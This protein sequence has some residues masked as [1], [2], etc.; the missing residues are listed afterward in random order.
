MKKAWMTLNET[1]YLKGI[2]FI[3]PLMS[4][5]SGVST[6]LYAPSLPAIASY[7]GVSVTVVKN[8]ISINFLGFAIGSLLFGLLMDR[9]GRKRMIVFAM[10]WFTVASL[11]AAICQHI[12]A[13]LAMRWIQG[14]VIASVA[15]GSRALVV[16]YFSGRRFFIVLL[17]VSLGY[18][19]G[20]IIGPVIG[21]YLQYHIGWRANFYALAIMSMVIIV[22]LMLVVN[23]NFSDREPLRLSEA[24][25]SYWRIVTH[26]AFLAGEVIIGIVQV[27]MVIYPTLGPFLIQNHLGYSA[28]VYGNSALLVG[29]GYLIGTLMNRF[30]LRYFSPKPLVLAG[31]LLFTF[32]LFCQLVLAEDVGMTLWTLVLPI[33]LINIAFGLIFANILGTCLQFFSDNAAVAAAIHTFICMLAGAMGVFIISGF[34]ISHLVSLFFVYLVMILVQVVILFFYFIGQFHE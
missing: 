3:L 29:A 14:V 5:L 15:V 19:L 18:S 30:L 6:D 9:Y 1:A 23:E 2:V 34:T 21:G 16:D 31:F 26:P 33:M 22:A 12:V 27:E 24:L 25:K 8:S 17:Y 11:Y 4:F 10:V 7:F 20:P 13:F 32:S 28:I